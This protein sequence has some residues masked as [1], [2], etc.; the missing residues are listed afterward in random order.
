MASAF[1]VCLFV[2]IAYLSNV[3]AFSSPIAQ[4]S[5]NR[6]ILIS[7]DPLATHVSVE[8]LYPFQSSIANHADLSEKWKLILLEG[9]L[10]QRLAKCAKQMDALWLSTASRGVLPSLG[11]AVATEEQCE[12]L[13]THLLWQVETIRLHGFSLQEFSDVKQQLRKNLY[14]ACPLVY[15]HATHCTSQNVLEEIQLSDLSSLLVQYMQN[16]QRRIHIIC[17]ESTSSPSLTSSKIEEMGQK[18]VLLALWHPAY[19]PEA[20][21]VM[22][23]PFHK[24]PQEPQTEPTRIQFAEHSPRAEAPL[25]FINHPTSLAPIDNSFYILREEEKRLVHKLLKAMAEKS[26]WGLLFKKKE[27][28]KLGKKVNLIHPMRF[29]THILSDHEL[30]KYLQEVK[31]SSFKWDHFIDG[32]AKRMKEETSKNNVYSHID[33]MAYLLNVQQDIIMQYIQSKDYEGLVRSIL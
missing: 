11:R 6:G 30:R 13:L 19:L 32:F 22:E 24:E 29:I 26:I 12:N 21:P 23:R 17:P 31:K 9:L 10:Q 1:S 3:T 4:Q 2:A 20:A 16:E 27:M 14:D 7:K 5:E 15:N 33:G 8:I 28:E 25:F 18:A